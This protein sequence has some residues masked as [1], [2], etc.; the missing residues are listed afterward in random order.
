METKE[1]ER[2]ILKLAE[3]ILKRIYGEYKIDES[4]TD[5]PDASIILEQN[6]SNKIGIEITCIDKEDIKQYFND[7]KISKEIEDEQLKQLL[8]NK[9]SK[10]PIKKHTISFDNKYIYDGVIKK[11]KKYISYKNSDTYTEIILLIWSS[12]LRLDYKYF[13]NYLIPFT[14]HFLREENFQFNK[15]IFVCE[16][17]KKNIIVYNKDLT[18]TKIENLPHID[19]NKE[20]GTTISKT[21]ILPFGKNINIKEITNNPPLIPKISK[22]SLII[23]RK[24]KQKAQKSSRRNNRFK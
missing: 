7:K 23:E 19:L 3:P 5:K 12:Y 15:V 11:N 8:N 6:V 24:K 9:Y 1:Q 4:Q 22:K 14:Q 20:K 17:T 16:S 2:E 10:N 21:S 18:K 13:E